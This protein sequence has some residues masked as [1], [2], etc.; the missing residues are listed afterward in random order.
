MFFAAQVRDMIYQD[1][2][3]EE[4]LGSVRYASVMLGLH[5][6]GLTHSAWMP[7]S[8]ALIEIFPPGSHKSS[9]EI[10]AKVRNRPYI[11]IDPSVGILRWVVGM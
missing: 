3:M 8:A 4:Q 7:R 5:G 10:F 9:Y 11:A 6:A 2:T 1:M